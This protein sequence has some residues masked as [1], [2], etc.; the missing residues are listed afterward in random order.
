LLRHKRTAGQRKLGTHGK[1]TARVHGVGT[2]RP[3][4]MIVDLELAKGG[5]N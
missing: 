4:Q 3:N 1:R 2:P 5:V